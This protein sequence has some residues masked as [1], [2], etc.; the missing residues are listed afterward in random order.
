[1]LA[2]DTPRVISISGTVKPEINSRLLATKRGMCTSQSSMRV[3]TMLAQMVGERT[4]L[5]SGLPLVLASQAP[6]VNCSSDMVTMMV[7]A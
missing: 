5:R 7:M 3:A 1:M 6:R 2:S 4:T